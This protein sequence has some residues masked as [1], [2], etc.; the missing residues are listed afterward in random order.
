MVK[1]LLKMIHVLEGLKQ[2][3]TSKNVERVQAAISKDQRLTVQE[4][5][6]DLG[7]PET[8]ESEILMQDL[9]MKHVV[10]KFILQFLLPEQKVHH[11]VF[12]NDL[13]QTATNEPDLVPCNFWLFQ[14]LKSS[15]KGQRFQTT[16]EIQE[17]MM[18]QLMAIPTKDFAEY[19][20]Q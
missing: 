17:N 15:L 8:T 19:S 16:N 6:A 12:A 9:G 18:G 5:K 1:T 10:A 2:S 7:I 3:R 20:E 13:I 4:L 11:V 14:K